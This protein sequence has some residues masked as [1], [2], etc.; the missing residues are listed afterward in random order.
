MA[1]VLSET[2]VPFSKSLYLCQDFPD[3]ALDLVTLCMTA[4]PSFTVSHS[5]FT[6]QLLFSSL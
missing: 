4:G 1:Y 5:I 6:R 2:S 3:K